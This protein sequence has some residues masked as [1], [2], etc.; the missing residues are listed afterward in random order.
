MVAV[1]ALCGVG[2]AQASGWTTNFTTSIASALTDWTQD[3]T[4]PQY[5]PAWSGGVTLTQIDLSV[6]SLLDTS[7]FIT[8]GSTSVSTGVLVRTEITISIND[9]GLLLAFTNCNPWVDKTFPSP[10]TG[11]L[12]AP[13][14]FMNLPNVGS[15]SSSA[16]QIEHYT[17]LTAP[18]V[19]NEF[20]GTGNIALPSSAQ[21]ETWT[22]ASDGNATI[23]QIT[24]ADLTGTITYW[25]AIPEPSTVLLV[26]LGLAAVVWR[27]RRRP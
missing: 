26:G 3:L 5:N 11:W 21:A 8:N 7:F 2:T 22:E 27:L 15:Y 14:A 18:L 9:P 17:T 24:H 20:T 23:S 1:I 4:F 6:S 13:G 10:G 25:A 19:M 12:L 16:S